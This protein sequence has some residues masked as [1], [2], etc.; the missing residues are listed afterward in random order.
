MSYNVLVVD[1]S[2]VSRAVMA[3]TLRLAEIPTG[4]LHEAANG[5]EALEILRT[6]WVDIVFADINMPVMGGIELVDTM[7]RDGL[8]NTV[9][10]VL[11]T[12]EGSSAKINRLREQGVSAYIRKPFTPEQ[13]REVFDT[14]L[15]GRRGRDRL[16][17][18]RAAFASVLEKFA[19]MFSEAVEKEEVREPSSDAIGATIS[20]SGPVSGALEMILPAEMCPAVA[21]NV[22]GVDPDDDMAVKRGEDALKELLNVTCG[23][24]LTGLAGEKAEF[25]VSM[26]ETCRVDRAQWGERRRRDDTAAF[27]VDS[28]PVLLRLQIDSK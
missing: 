6:H 25:T 1:D 3:K 26:P 11:V 19:F 24:V 13:I 2:A 10:V 16:G 23:Q 27:V 8:L 20:F 5:K 15:T 18:A 17:V 4:E 28:H 21:A 12:I 9:P 14:V 7:S 22:L